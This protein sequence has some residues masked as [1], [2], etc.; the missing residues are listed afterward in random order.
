MDLDE[1]F[2]RTHPDSVRPEP[3]PVEQTPARLIAV[4]RW[5]AGLSQAE[6]AQ[7]ASTSQQAVGRYE[8]GQ[9]APSLEL[10]RRLLAACGQRLELTCVP[11]AGLVDRPTLDLLAL[12]PVERLSDDV[13]GAV[14]PLIPV[15]H[16][17]GQPAL[18]ADRAAAR[19][20]GALVRVRE[21]EFWVDEDATDV[22]AL[23]SAL[24][25]LG[26]MVWRIDHRSPRFP[27]TRL[28]L[29]RLEGGFSGCDLRFRGFD[30][31]SF[32]LD[33][34]ATVET[35]SGELR[36]TGVSDT[37]LYWHARDRAHLALQRA[38]ALRAEA[39]GPETL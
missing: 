27:S 20:R 12:P 22:A 16:G 25:E 33:R 8:K 15:L 21:I 4:A 18:L 5:H 9:T 38:V 1:P 36:V 34:A 26:G 32:R 28:R 30:D 24:V 11:Q 19:I 13:R 23:E 3:C 17:L 35:P 31:L 2:L 14:L 6:L 10:L 29:G 37:S 7:R 39:A